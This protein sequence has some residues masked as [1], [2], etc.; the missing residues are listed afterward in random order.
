MKQTEYYLKHRNDICGLLRFDP[1]DGKL[2]HF[3]IKEKE[4]T[5]F[6]GNADPAKMKRWWEAR[7]V[8][9][10][11][12]MMEE[13]IRLA[14]CSNRYDYLAKN[15]GLSMTDCYW[16]CPTDETLKWEDVNL[17]RLHLPGSKLPY[18]NI[19]S[20]DPNASLG[21]Q[22]DKYWDLSGETPV[23]IKTA[24]P[25]H[26]QQCTNEVL[27]TNI[28]AGQPASVP[29]V[30]YTAKKNKDGGRI[31]F[32][33]AFTDENT[34]FISAYEVVSSEKKENSRSVYDSYI[35]I[36]SRHGID[37]RAMR[38][39]MD[40]QTL[41]DFAISN[42]DRHLMN[43]GVLRDSRTLKLIGPAPVF[44]SGNSMFYAEDR[45]KPF[46]GTELLERKITSF[47]DSEGRMLSHVQNKTLVNTE[48]LPAPEEVASFYRQNGIPKKKAD[49]IAGSYAV[50]LTLLHDFQ[51]GKKISVFLEKQKNRYV[52]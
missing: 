27:A 31:S 14:G 2:T 10:T 51:S 21:G 35:S 1:D 29:Y 42:S 24:Y 23:L 3:K 25:H 9:G 45:T 52:N 44:D 32:C 36:C 40:Y 37:S 8:P 28:H 17:F 7:A 48:A 43:F 16:L 19:T 34:E 20:Y 47:H 30:S 18:H 11:R 49:F 39:F 15:L 13:V 33:D 22:M 41:T 5:P 6:L 26:G 4:L 38:T 46:T 50:K 12:K